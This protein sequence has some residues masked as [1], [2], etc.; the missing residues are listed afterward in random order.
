MLLAIAI[1]SLLQINAFNPVNSNAQLKIR[2]KLRLNFLEVATEETITREQLQVQ[3]CIR[4]AKFNDLSSVVNLRVAVFYPEVSWVIQRIF[5]NSSIRQIIRPFTFLKL[6]QHKSL[7]TFHTLILQKIRKRME[8]GSVCLLAHSTDES[9]KSGTMIYGK[10]LGTVEFSAS[11]FINTAME[12]F[13]S[14][15]KIYVAD[16]AVRQD[17]R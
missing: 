15:R 7:S 8:A 14:S 13:G 11:D 9:N 4:E 2:K 5:D 17:V 3:L 16:L 6:T 12:D 10:L 1:I